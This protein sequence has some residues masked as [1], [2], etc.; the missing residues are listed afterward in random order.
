MSVLS[1]VP[2]TVKDKSDLLAQIE[3]QGTPF[4]IDGATKT[5]YVLSAE[6]LLVLFRSM[7]SADIE[8]DLSFTPQDFGLTEADLAA[9]EARRKTR[10]EIVDFRSLEPLSVELERRLR[11][12]SQVERQQPL[13]DDE[14]REREQL[15]HQLEAAMLHNLQVIVK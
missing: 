11:H 15:L 4:R 9:Y 6:Q 13:T 14:V 10:R 7:V 1:N 5:Y 8:S 2:D 3:E 12:L